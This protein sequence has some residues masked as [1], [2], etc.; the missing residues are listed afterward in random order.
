[1]VSGV[2]RQGF[3]LAHRRLGLV[4]RDVLWKAVW[5]G[6][7]V[8]SLLLAAAWFGDQVQSAQW[9]TSNIPAVNGVI[10]ATVLR[11][12]WNEHAAEMFWALS[13]VIVLSSSLWVVLEAFFRARILNTPPIPGGEFV[14][15]KMYLASGIAK[16]TILLGA[17]IALGLITFSRYL[18]TP[19][20]EW[21]ALWLETRGAGI[22]S[23]VAFLGLAFLLT[24]ID[25]LVRGDAIELF[26]TDLIR[27]SGVIGILLM[28]EA[29]IGAS[30]AIVIVIGFLN[31]GSAAE[32]IAMLG[33]VAGGVLLVSLLHSYLL[34]VRF[35][36]IGIM[37]H[38]VVE[39]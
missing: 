36:A 24:V 10:A 4:F 3:A 9:Q 39:I 34:L 28:F 19:L 35:S 22:V 20:S 26:G 5:L 29:L 14:G 31:V 11:Q 15:F 12:F 27:V 37:R 7:T 1:M 2:L 32:A 38:N 16:I 6:V 8:A 21:P 18:T 17:A 33:V 23:L 30:I 13:G 25:T